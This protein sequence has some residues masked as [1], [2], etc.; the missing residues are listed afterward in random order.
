MFY[1]RTILILITFG[2]YP[3]SIRH[4]FDSIFNG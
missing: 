4:Q 1:L 3:M 2:F